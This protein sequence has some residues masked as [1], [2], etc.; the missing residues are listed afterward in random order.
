MATKQTVCNMPFQHEQNTSSSSG[1]IQ[2]ALQDLEG[3]DSLMMWFAV[4]TTAVKLAQ[5]GKRS[6]LLV[7]CTRCCAKC[8]Q[9]LDPGC[10]KQMTKLPFQQ[11]LHVLQ[12]T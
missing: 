2:V 12:S 8:A 11:L 10:Q 7:A 3:L 4:R 6:K 9:W 1:Q 5:A